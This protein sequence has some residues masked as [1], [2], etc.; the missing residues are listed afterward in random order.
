MP[1]N[2][3]RRYASASGDYNPIH[4]YSPTARLLGFRR[5]VVHGMWSKARCVAALQPGLGT[6]RCRI[7]VAF[8]T[9]V[10][11][12]ADVSLHHGETGQ[13]LDFELRDT[14]G[15]KPHLR[16]SMHAL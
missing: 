5:Q 6:D 2:L 4:L 14:A 1:A 11:L 16:G 9:P 3:G 8:K 15:E 7:E 13:S 10:F 12:P